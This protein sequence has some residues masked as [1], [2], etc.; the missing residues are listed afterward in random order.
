ML[1]FFKKKKFNE[2]IPNK[3]MMEAAIIKGNK[4]GL[5]RD[6]IIEMISLMDKKIGKGKIEKIIDNIIRRN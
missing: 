6:E 3:K 5:K 4:I 1:S 2:F